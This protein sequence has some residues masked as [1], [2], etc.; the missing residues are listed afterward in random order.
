MS[1]IVSQIIEYCSCQDIDEKDVM[2]AID[3]VSMFTGWANK[4]CETF[5]VGERK[6]VIELPACI[7]CTWVFKPFYWPYDEESFTFTLVTQKGLEE[8]SESVEFVYSEV[9]ENFRLD[10]PNN[11]KCGGRCKCGCIPTY[12]LVVVYNAGYD[13]IP[14]CLLPVFC[15]L[16][17]VIHEKNLC[18]K[19]SCGCSSSEENQNYSN[20]DEDLAK[21]L[22]ETMKELLT[23]QYKRQLGMISLYRYRP[24]VWGTVI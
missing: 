22:E 15:E 13:A 24:E 7:P 8:T 11:C 23:E 19:D 20:E 16:V 5:L 6:E 14:D 10:L 21:S 12:K 18:C 4:P 2:E 3:L 9:D 1:D 17:R